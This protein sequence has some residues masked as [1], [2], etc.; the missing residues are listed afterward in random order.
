MITDHDLITIL[1][2][3]EELIKPTLAKY[4]LSSIPIRQDIL[5]GEMEQGIVFFYSQFSRG[6]VANDKTHTLHIVCRKMAE[7]PLDQYIIASE[8][9]SD[10]YSSG[11]MPVN[12]SLIDS[13]H[14]ADELGRMTSMLTYKLVMKEC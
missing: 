9:D 14:G 5:P 1:N 8:I 2:Q 4:D 7:S 12:I 3:L 6:G 11:Q 13:F 10:L